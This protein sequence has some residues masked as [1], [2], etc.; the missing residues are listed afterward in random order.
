MTLFSKISL[1]ALTGI[2]ALTP[3]DTAAMEKGDADSARPRSSLVNIKARINTLEHIQAF[4]TDE[5][6]VEAFP[7]FMAIAQDPASSK[8]KCLEI[9]RN[10]IW[11]GEM[12]QR[13]TLCS[14]FLSLLP[15]YEFSA[16]DYFTATKI[17]ACHGTADQKDLATLFLL[18]IM[19][20]AMVLPSVPGL[21]LPLDIR[22]GAG[23]Q[24][25]DSGTEEHQREAMSFLMTLAEDSKAPAEIRSKAAEAIL[26][27]NQTVETRMQM[28]LL[29]VSDASFAALPGFAL[30]H[31]RDPIMISP[32]LRA[33][34]LENADALYYGNTATFI[35]PDI[36]EELIYTM[37]AQPQ[38]QWQ[39]TIAGNMPDQRARIAAA[40]QEFVKD[41]GDLHNRRS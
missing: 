16:K 13:R 7:E 26:R 25:L 3:F 36:K 31:P 19:Q 17:I 23:S 28:L 34:L 15:C 20:D 32:E 4:G 37:A 11:F 6:K 9:T 33:F 18:A 8:T 10:F 35:L 41:L 21:T 22:L 30:E 5:E 27:H 2:L 14:I 40:K 38:D 24:I 29:R 39:A 12:E 1:L